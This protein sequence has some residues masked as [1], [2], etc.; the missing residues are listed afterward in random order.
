MRTGRLEHTFVAG[1]ELGRQVTDNLRLTAYFTSIGPTTTAVTVPVSAPKTSSPVEFRQNA[2]DADNHG[3]AAQAAIYVQDQIA[4][5]RHVDAILGL[6]YDRFHVD[7]TNNRTASDVEGEDTLVSPRLGLVY[8]PI[9][10]VALYGSYTLSYLPRAGEQLASLTVTNEALEPEEF[11][12]YEVGAKWDITSALSFT[13]A[14][15]RLNRGNVVVADPLDPTVSL[16]VDA[17]RT[18][19]L[20]LEL[21]G[22]PATRWDVVAGYAYQR[23]EITRSISATVLAGARLGQV[24]AQAL[25]VWN[26]VRL[27]REWGVG[28]GVIARSKSFVATDNA[29]VLPAFG[30]VDAAVFYSPAGR[31]GVQINVENLLDNRYYPTA[32]SNNNIM[33]GSPRAVRLALSTRF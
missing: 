24:P 11:R 4:I 7:L 1:T 23:G 3:V 22:R 20:E 21:G 26:K 27:G 25:S 5:S 14:I 31:V 12:N 10:P 8:K 15:Y 29:V 2:T 18:S 30:R 16:L 9:A 33:P 19:G 6:R 13:A 17:Q 28:L 32:H